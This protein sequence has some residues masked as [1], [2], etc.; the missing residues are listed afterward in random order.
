MNNNLP[1]KITIQDVYLV[2][3]EIYIVLYQNLKYLPK[4]F[5]N[6]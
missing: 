6:A 4:L 1:L 2:L 5:D 3:T